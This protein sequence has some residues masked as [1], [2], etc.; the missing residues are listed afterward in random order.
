[1]GGG[2]FGIV[3]H[4]RI[5]DTEPVGDQACEGGLSSLAWTVQDDCAER[6]QGFDDDLFGVSLN[7]LC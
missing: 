6:A 3:V 7:E 1:L 4:G 2:A 5:G